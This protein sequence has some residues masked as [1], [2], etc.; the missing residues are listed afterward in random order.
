MD[1]VFKVILVIVMIV[2]VLRLLNYVLNSK[3]S[4]EDL[5]EISKQEYEVVSLEEEDEEEEEEEKL[6][7]NSYK[8]KT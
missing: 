7:K 5:K 2:L 8:L 4:G 6:K 1:L 3:V